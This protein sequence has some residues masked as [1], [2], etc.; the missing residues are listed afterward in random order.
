MDRK[1]IGRGRR[2][3]WVELEGETWDLPGV[4]KGFTPIL[5]SEA[6]VLRCGVL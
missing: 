2:L 4:S 1:G 5:F 6:V 3:D